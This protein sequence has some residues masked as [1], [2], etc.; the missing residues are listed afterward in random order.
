MIGLLAAM[1]KHLSQR[2][3]APEVSSGGPWAASSLTSLVGTSRANRGAR[4][5]H[6]PPPRPT[7]G[8][9]IIAAGQPFDVGRTVVLWSDEQGFDA[10][11]KCAASTRPAAAATSIPTATARARADQAQP[12]EPAG[13]RFAVRA[14]LR[15]LRQLAFVLQVDAQPHAPG[16]GTGCGLSAHFMIDTDGTIYQTLD[17]AERAYHAEQENS[18]SVGVEICNRGPLQP[19]RVNK[20]PAE[21]RTRPRA[22]WSSTASKYDAYDFRP[23]QYESIVALTRTLLRIF[24]KMKPEVP[25]RNGEVI[26]DTLEDP[27]SFHGIVGHLHVDLDKQKWDPGALDWKRIMRALQ[28]FVFPMQIRAFTEVPRTRDDLL[29]ARRAAFFSSEERAT[30]FFPACPGPTLAFG[31]PPARPRRRNRI[32]ADARSHRGRAQ[33]RAKR[34]VDF[35][36]AHQARGRSGRPGHHLLLAA[37]PPEP[38]GV[39][40]GQSRALDASP[41]AAGS[42]R[43]PPIHRIGRRHPAR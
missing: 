11:Q 40:R 34:L 13:H 20:L 8:T 38:A 29:S 37:G 3:R 1:V 24:P 15:R 35:V 30:G 32:G 41:H 19:R 18:I 23:E 33:G 10:Y 39:R 25:E 22:M 36:R 14:A 12:R 28:G 16:G 4:T 9:A 31:R 7:R 27:L 5:D 21:W 17:L 43:C 2:F 6:L 26:M 42:G